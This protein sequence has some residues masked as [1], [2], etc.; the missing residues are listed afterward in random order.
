MPKGSTEGVRRRKEEMQGKLKGLG[1]TREG[2]SV[3]SL[4]D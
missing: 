3:G 1:N 2:R 4:E